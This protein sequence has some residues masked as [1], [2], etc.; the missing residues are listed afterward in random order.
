MEPADPGLHENSFLIVIASEAKAR[1]VGASSRYSSQS[2]MLLASP[3]RMKIA[4]VAL[5]SQAT[6]VRLCRDSDF[7]GGLGRGPHPRFFAYGSE[8]HF[9]T[10]DE[11][12]FRAKRT[13]TKA[14]SR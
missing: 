4:S 10:N 3:R 7:V 13:D 1:Q 2:N 5:R 12:S 8:W 11:R 9:R 14:M 6:K